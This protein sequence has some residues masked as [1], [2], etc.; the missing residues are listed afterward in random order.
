MQK[1]REA[2]GSGAGSIS[3]LK[4]QLDYIHKSAKF[5][6]E[7]GLQLR[8]ARI[9]GQQPPPCAVEATRPAAQSVP[10]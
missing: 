2:K 10:F 9:P 3:L 4:R 6:D 1:P 7:F 5:S 8:F